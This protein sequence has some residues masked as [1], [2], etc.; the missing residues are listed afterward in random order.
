MIKASGNK[1]YG[2][3]ALIEQSLILNLR[4]LRDNQQVFIMPTI[5]NKDQ[6]SLKLQAQTAPNTRE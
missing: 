2:L 5:F 4:H 3:E 6:W 1:T